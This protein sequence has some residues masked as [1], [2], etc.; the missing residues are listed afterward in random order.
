MKTEETSDE[1]TSS[2]VGHVSSV[3]GGNGGFLKKPVKKEEPED[4]DFLCKKAGCITCSVTKHVCEATGSLKTRKIRWCF[5]DLQL[6]RSLRFLLFPGWSRFWCG[7]RCFSV[8]HICKQWVLSYCRLEPVCP[9]SFQFVVT[10]SIF[11]ELHVLLS[12]DKWIRSGCS[13]LHVRHHFLA[14][15]ISVRS[16]SVT[17]SGVILNVIRDLLDFVLSTILTPWVKIGIGLVLV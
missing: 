10:C 13:I 11:S 9:F 8:L 4:E 12:T 17:F 16:S 6:S 14:Y 7:L 5:S 1:I 15:L 2:S 3:D